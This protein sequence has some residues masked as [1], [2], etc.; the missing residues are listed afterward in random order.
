MPTTIKQLVEK[1]RLSSTDIKKVKWN[2]PIGCKEEGIYIVS[3]SENIESNK[4]IKEFPISM[5]ILETWIK[6]LD[7]FII[8]KKETK[9]SKIIRERLSEFWIPDESILYI[10][11]AP[12]RKRGGGIGNRFKSIMIQ[13]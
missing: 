3:L 1:V 11:K 7:Y 10:G 5:T 6:K 2:T 9:D 12:L 4:T 13:L 8:D